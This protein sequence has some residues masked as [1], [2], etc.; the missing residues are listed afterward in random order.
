MSTRYTS[1]CLQRRLHVL[2][3]HA[4]L[5]GPLAFWL[6]QNSTQCAEFF[7]PTD[8][9]SPFLI[10]ITYSPK[11]YLPSHWWQVGKPG[12]LNCSSSF[13][14]PTPYPQ[15]FVQCLFLMNALNSCNSITK[16]TK[17]KKQTARSKNGQKT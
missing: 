4:Q 10:A 7:C 14:A 8:P 9:L 17:M 11:A 6:L 5:W 1:N 15:L 13:I 3:V 16:S 2:T 12:V